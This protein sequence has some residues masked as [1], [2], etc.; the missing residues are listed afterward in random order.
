[1]LLHAWLSLVVFALL[2]SI[3][4]F[5][6]GRI[7]EDSVRTEMLAEKAALAASESLPRGAAT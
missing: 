6:A 7:V 1:M 4:G 3:I 2:G 5:L